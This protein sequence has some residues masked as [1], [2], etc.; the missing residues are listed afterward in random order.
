M[1]PAMEPIGPDEPFRFFCRKGLSCFGTCCRDLNHF[2][3]PYDI[4]KIK[5]ALNLTSTQFLERYTVHHTGPRS[6]LPVI[7]L[8]TGDCPGRPCPFLTPSGC[9]IYEDR[10]TACRLYPVARAVSRNRKTHRTTV[11]FALIR[12]PFCRGFETTREQTVAAWIEDQNAREPIRMNDRLLDLIALKN[13]FWPGSLP[14]SHQRFFKTALYD[15]DRFRL[16]IKKGLLQ[17]FLTEKETEALD[18]M[19]DLA[20]LELGHRWVAH[21]LRKTPERMQSDESRR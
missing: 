20:L 7:T 1:N 3:T 4:C 2:L 19:D 15:L 17:D 8:G 14:P 6:G 18:L 5:N 11:H 16:E 9:R 10:P 13:R 21:M 12:E